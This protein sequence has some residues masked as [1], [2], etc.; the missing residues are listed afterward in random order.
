MGFYKERAFIHRRGSDEVKAAKQIYKV[1]DS[2]T[3]DID[4][5]GEIIAEEYS[6]SIASRLIYLSDVVEDTKRDNGVRII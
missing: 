3:L 6:N 4:E 2:I 1:L 5:V